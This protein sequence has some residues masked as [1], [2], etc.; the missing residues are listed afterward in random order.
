MIAATRFILSLSLVLSLTVAAVAATPWQ[1]RSNSAARLHVAVNDDGQIVAGL[2]VRLDDGWKTYWRSAG[3]T[4]LP[5]QIDTEGSVNV[6]SFRVAYPAPER[7]VAFGIEALGYSHT[8]TFPVTIE[9]SNADQ[10][11]RLALRAGLLVCGRVCVPE[12]YEFSTPV[13]ADLA[14][15]PR[16]E[17]TPIADAMAKVPVPA[18]DADVALALL[19]AT[20]EG[21]SVTLKA[22]GDR[23]PRLDDAL[24]VA[25]VEGED[26]LIGRLAH[27]GG[28]RF[29]ATLAG[30]TLPSPG[31]EVRLT[32]AGKGLAL[33][34]SG[35]VATAVIPTAAPTAEPARGLV[36]IFLIAFLGGLILNAMPCVLPV[37]SIKV[38]ALG[39]ATI[40]E[41]RQQRLA[42]LATAGGIAVFIILLGSVLSALKALG[43]D[44]FWGMQFQEPVF[45]ALLFGLFV[46]MT[47]NLAGIFEFRPPAGL[48]NRLGRFGRTGDFADGF[49]IALVATPCSAPFLGTAIGFGLAG[50]PGELAVAFA[51]L[52]AGFAAPYLAIAAI[53]QTVS[54]LPK[55]GQWM[56]WL[57]R[58]LALP[59]LG[60]VVW[61][62][63]ILDSQ[64][65]ADALAAAAVAALA[66][67][68]AANR[69]RRVTVVLGAA[70]VVASTVYV[71]T[72]VGSTTP[73]EHTV[74]AGE[75]KTFDRAA[76][77]SHVTKGH[78]VF[79][80]VTADWCITCVYNKAAALDR[81]AVR[82]ELARPDTVAMRADWT[83]PDDAIAD[84]VKAQGRYGIP[85]NVAF[86]PA[87]P[88]GILL[89]EILTV[90][91][92]LDAI[93]TARGDRASGSS[94]RK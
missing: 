84:F 14:L 63:W 87:A 90:S 46:L 80:D 15:L 82:I 78:V 29:A 4:G 37:L 31:T 62:A 42:F 2:E 54:V 17:D 27:R 49:V 71:A 48:Q 69:P 52:G 64:A 30:P 53:P 7:F 89:P 1:E 35:T 85:L 41:R 61:L 51:A 40:L 19:A 66:V 26:P 5:P 16:A 44:V 94:N 36:A 55:P 75:W 57:Q 74:E 73:P 8:V 11:A 65:G 13:P 3:S 91:T 83:L 22:F 72:D 32:V 93:A 45:V 21:L 56:A 60:V 28:G 59:M 76:I 79:V 9:R 6:A 43:R 38:A 33:D 77:E 10:G 58:A 20:E 18:L 81:D 68:V 34:L 25:E 23:A 67:A 70:V 24:I 12:R 50:G 86:G 47:L 92:V 88:E 39:R